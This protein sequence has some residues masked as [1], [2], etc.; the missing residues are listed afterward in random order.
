MRCKIRTPI[1]FWREDLSY[2][3]DGV[4]KDPTRTDFGAIATKM[5]SLLTGGG[6]SSTNTRTTQRGQFGPI[7]QGDLLG[8]LTQLGLNDLRGMAR[9]YEI[10]TNGMGK[11]QL[12]EAI[13]EK[14]KQPE[15]VRRVAATLEKRQRQLLAALT[16]AG[17]SITDDDLHGLF[18]RFSLG[19]PNQLHATVAGLQAKA[20]LF[21]TSL[22]QSGRVSEPSKSSLNIGWYVPQEVRTVLRVSMPI[23]PFNDLAGDQDQPATILKLSEPYSLLVD[24]LLIAH[25]LDGYHLGKDDRWQQADTPDSRSPDLH[26]SDSSVPLPPPADMPPAPLL[27]SLR[28]TVKRSPAFLRFAVR[29][30]RLTDILYQDEADKDKPCLRILP[31]ATQ[32][33]LSSRRAKTLHDLFEVW[34]THSSY[35][36]LFELQENG[37]RLRCQSTSLNLPNLRSGEL[38]AENGEARQTIIA[39][40]AQAT[41][42]QWISFS[43]FVRFMY[44]LNPFFLQRQSTLFP[45]P[46]W[47][48]EQDKGR[49]LRPSQL[50]DWQQAESRYL[51]YFIRGPLHWWGICDLVTTKSGSL[52]AFRLTSL[53]NSLL[54]GLKPPDETAA[55][56]YQIQS[57]RLKILNANEL[58]VT[59]S[60]QTWPIIEVLETFAET[61]GIHND[62]L[63]YRLTPKALANALSHGHRPALLLELLRDVATNG[64][65]PD[66]PLAQMLTQLEQWILSYGHVRIYTGVSLLETADPVVMRELSATTSLDDQIVKPLHPTLLV[67]KNGAMNSL[68][69][70]LKRRGQFPLLYDEEFY[71]PERS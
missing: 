55:Q 17:G 30:L 4:E 45:T 43:G 21:R 63:H 40:L 24:L 50:N 66:S 65:S 35:G 27:S 5:P 36:E 46:H 31:N 58:L 61:A 15:A 16:L 54:N 20:L 62:C 32:L 33:L 67:L 37:L 64:T 18:Q 71:G 1:H 12:A 48:I 2:K 19:Q 28:E 70:D 44:R 59:C 56:D 26:S 42:N 68:V 3:G 69:E 51:E 9:E 13:M 6:T 11:Q 25:A 8:I 57:D 38:D 39:L 41:P 34:L 53:A 10:A 29:L 47:W 49:P 7:L 23:T 14:L 60:A 52:L 22:N